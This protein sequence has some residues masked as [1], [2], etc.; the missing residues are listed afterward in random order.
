M[1][2]LPMTNDGARR[3]DIDIITATYSFRTFWNYSTE[4]WYVDMVDSEGIDYL[5]GMA[6][7]PAI[8]ILKAH[9][10]Q[11]EETGDI[12]VSDSLATGNATVDSLGSDGID[13]T[14]WL[15]GEFEETNPEA[16][17]RLPDL[18]VDLDDIL[19]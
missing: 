3:A 4:M 1:L 11:V 19:Q 9:T 16:A 12:R 6:L 5:L 2:I 15:P 18:F 10:V 14:S 17:F 13:V 7:V 8:N